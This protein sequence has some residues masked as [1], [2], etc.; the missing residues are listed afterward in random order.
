MT[1][2][3]FILTTAGHVDHGKSAL[4]KALTGTD[5][6]RLPE[7]KARGITIE[8][9]FAHLILD[10]PNEQRFHIGIIDVPGHEDFVR[11]MIAG[12]GSVDLA[13]LVV[14]ADDGWMPQTEEHLQILSYLGVNRAVI[15]LTKSDLGK[16]TRR[17]DSSRGEID[18]VVT[19]IRA[20]L[21]D[22]T[23]ANSPIIPT[24]TR[25]NEGI[26]D[27]KN[28][29]A[30][31]LSVMEPQRD[32][33][34]P[35]LF[36]DRAFAL[37]GIGTVVTG[38]LSGGTLSRGQSVVVQPQ[39]FPGRI[40]SIQNHGQDVDLARPGMRTAI[41]LPDAA[42]G[43]RS[44]GIKRG[45][46]VT[47]ADL[48]PP[49]AALDVL[50]ER[51]PRLRLSQSAAAARPLKNG[52]TVYFHHG[53]ARV[54]AKIAFLEKNALACGEEAI[55]QLRLES[56]MFAFLSDRFVVRDPSER[57]TIAGGIVLDPNG[58]RRNFCNAAQLALL[59][60]R[61]TAPYDVDL[62]VR[63]EL[64]HRGFAQ[65]ETLLRKSNFSD[66]EIAAA[67]LRLQERKAIVLRGE[68][69]AD[70]EEWHDLFRRASALIDTVHEN[71]PE[72]HGLELAGLRVQLGDQP[73]DLFA[74]LISD[75]CANGF[76]RE[77][78]TI[79]RAAHR[80]QL[81]PQTR[82][83]AGKIRTLLAEK[84][85]DPP[86]RKD[87]TQDRHLHQALRFLIEQG[88]VIEVGAEVILLRQNF[89]RMKCKIVDFIS[90]NGP[91]TVSE[92]RQELKSSR[93]IIVPLLEHLDGRGITQREGDRRK[94][95]NQEKIRSAANLL[96]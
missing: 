68:I 62:C 7:E 93:R 73:G 25:D 75:L 72:Q 92:L 88:E 43:A 35:R 12:V 49:S 4:V 94:L 18:D 82:P 17:T 50:L 56:P 53:T 32:I 74:S 79:G 38:T 44:A 29:I 9:G 51:S 70:A 63:S 54:A 58:D 40:R 31:E 69:A 22:S 26:D 65:R 45:D 89:E 67:L 57:F 21:R 1:E 34:K 86:P 47:I 10:T 20:H 42:I 83:A 46:V 78:S 16:S 13:L 66:D 33:E 61:A 64:A 52:A 80:A 23:F 15:A 84:P 27:L 81:P 91:A 90:K 37:R 6:D 95:R 48:G 14:A 28:L 59:A 41:N 24:S 77:R 2:K 39:N 36:I 55:A 85:F 8:L 30:S 60:A 71:H 11:H 3:H 5:P 76:V 19:Q 87:L 96:Q